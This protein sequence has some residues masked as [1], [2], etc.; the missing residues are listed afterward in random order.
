MRKASKRVFPAPSERS[1]L[2]RRRQT[3]AGATSRRFGCVGCARPLHAKK[4]ASA[5]AQP[6]LLPVLCLG[7]PIA[8]VFTSCDTQRPADFAN[9][10]P[11][12]ASREATATVTSLD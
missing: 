2:G 12:A 1:S 10:H 5:A 9:F 6:T 4:R 11:R 3:D 7:D 8:H